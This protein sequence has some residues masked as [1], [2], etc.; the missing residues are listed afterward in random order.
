M[1]ETIARAWAVTR[2]DGMV[3]GFTD[4]DMALRFEGIEFRPD[5]GLSARAV[6]QGSGLSVGVRNGALETVAHW[7]VDAVAAPPAARIR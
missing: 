2:G 5:S 6:V 7:L 1:T 4:H 3:L